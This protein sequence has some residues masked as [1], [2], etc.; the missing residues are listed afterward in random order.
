MEQISQGRP[1][2]PVWSLTLGVLAIAGVAVAIAAWTLAAGI[3]ALPAKI[4]LWIVA[5]HGVLMTCCILYARFI[6]P[7]WIGVT[8]MTVSF[9]AKLRIAIIGDFHVNETKGEA[10][11]A[12]AVEHCNA[13]E[14]DLVL[15]VGD[16]LYDHTSDLQLLTPLKNLRAK[17]G[18]FAVV[19]NHDS[20]H[21][22]LPGRNTK[23]KVDR[24]DDIQQLLEPLGIAFLRNR[25]TTID[26][27][28]ETIHV[29]G[30]DDVWM[31]SCNLQSALK[32][33]PRDASC[34]LLSHQPDVILDP[35]SHRAQIIASGHT[36]GGQIRLPWLGPL[37]RLPQ[38][39]NNKFDR[40]LFRVTPQ[41]TLA[42]T[43]GIG[44][45]HIPVRFF[46]RPEILLLDA[47]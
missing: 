2:R 19:G 30:I 46:A 4:A 47:R 24:S 40:G 6:E 15:L 32:D 13:E 37:C 3:D 41:C 45:M 35:M 31:D 7:F 20:G 8:R 1:G 9:P 36:H 16:F 38:R 27:D 26:H 28:G 18:V 14:P 43:H 12:K 33:V 29:A 44:E 42:L 11:V 39:L 21:D 5:F 23:R 22:H 10:F 17:Y 34:I 25:S